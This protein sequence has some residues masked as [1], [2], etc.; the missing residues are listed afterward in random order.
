[1]INK[2]IFLR[3]RKLS[4]NLRNLLMILYSFYL[5][6]KHLI[7]YRKTNIFEIV[8]LETTS[9]CNRK[10]L[11]CPVSKYKRAN[12]ILELKYIRKIFFEL[13]HLN[14]KGT[15][16]FGR[17]DEPLM[18]SRIKIIIKYLRDY[19][20]NNEVIIYTNGDFLSLNLF[21][22]LNKLNIIF[23]ITNHQKESNI[24]LKNML[25]NIPKEQKNHIYVRTNIENDIL[26]PRSGLVKV[27]NPTKQ[28]CCIIPY[29]ELTFDYEGNIV[30]CPD[31]YF[32]SIKFGNIKKDRI[33]DVWNKE[34]YKKIR[35]ELRLGKKRFPICKC[36]K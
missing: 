15:I 30:L 4:P 35:R 8:N 9:L 31:D 32:S 22:K 18:D 1:M 3:T 12:K 5:D 29:I 27:K 33:I 25:N 21:K 2:T 20:P 36:I 26:N 7:Q 17:Y 10:C 34:E 28:S 19:L 24:N 11:Y 14:F 16:I 13:S 23:N 6:I